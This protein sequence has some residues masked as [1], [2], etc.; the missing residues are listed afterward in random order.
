MNL[1]LSVSSPQEGSSSDQ[2]SVGQQIWNFHSHCI[3]YKPS[4]S[5]YEKLIDCPF[6]ILW[7]KTLDLAEILSAKYDSMSR[8][9]YSDGLKKLIKLD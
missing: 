2:V 8:Q 6:L 4:T 5:D 3:A 9:M 1:L 7:I